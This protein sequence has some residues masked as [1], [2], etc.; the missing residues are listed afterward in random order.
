MRLCWSQTALLVV[1]AV[2]GVL[3]MLGGCGSKG[4]LYLP[5]EPTEQQSE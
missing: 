5:T 1:V 4:P 3:S 2:L